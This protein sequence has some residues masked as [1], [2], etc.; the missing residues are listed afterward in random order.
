VA[1]DGML[2][3]LGQAEGKDTEKPVR[4]LPANANVTDMI[5]VNQILYAATTN[6]CG[7]VPNGLWAVDLASDAK[8]VVSWK[9]PASPVGAP[10]LS[11]NG[12]V[13]VATADGSLTA[14]DPKTLA[15]KDSFHATGTAFS[16]TPTIFSYKDHEMVAVAA[17][18]G[19]IFLLDTE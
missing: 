9:S 4:F 6:G 3:A 15:V 18:D 10:A 14:L 8:A 17:K 7:G 1:S 16:S 5:E 19:R 11:S 13:F 2:H 12:A